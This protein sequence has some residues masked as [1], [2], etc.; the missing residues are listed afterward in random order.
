MNWE[1]VHNPYKKELKK[2]LFQA[3]YFC[4]SGNR[5]KIRFKWKIGYSLSH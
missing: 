2:Q 5:V 1:S 4:F 3:V